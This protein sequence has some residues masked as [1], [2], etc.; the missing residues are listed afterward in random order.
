MTRPELNAPAVAALRESL[1]SADYTHDGIRAAIGAPAMDALA[2]GDFEAAELTTRD[3][4]AIHTLVRLFLIGETVSMNEARDALPF[5][6]AWQLGLVE[7]VDGD[8]RASLDLRPYAADSDIWWVVSD[9][10]T[11]QR[12]ASGRGPILSDHVLGVGGASTTLAQ[13]A[14]RKAVGSA[15]DLGTGCGVQSL[16]LSKHASSVIA[17]DINSRALRLAALTAAINEMEISFREGDLLRPVQ[18]E[19]FDQIVSNPPFV[20]GAGDGGFTYRDSG[21]SGDTITQQLVRTLPALLN[22]GGSAQLLANWMHVEGEDWRERV[23]SWVH[24][25]GCDA[26]IIQRDIQDPA[27]Y[28]S[29]WMSDA[30]DGRSTDHRAR[31]DSWFEWLRE[32]KVEGIGFGFVLL[33]R[34]ESTPVIVTDE[35]TQ[36]ISPPLGAQ[37]TSWFARQ[38]WLRARSDDAVLDSQLTLSADVTLEQ[39]ATRDPDGGWDV[40]GQVLRQESG[41]RWREDVDQVVADLAAGCDGRQSIRELMDV[42]D[43]LYSLAD[44][45]DTSALMSATATAVRHLVARGFLDF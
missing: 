16:H 11:E 6:A 24:G 7:P 44:P 17:T 30:G 35:L 42:L 14:P 1:Q 13:L 40:V 23:S 8:V 19:R 25:N 43:A 15:L 12:R 28:V 27:E 45:L 20:V 9:L 22:P 34:T 2:R 18:D 29:L 5:A 31:Y 4:D 32:H 21:L 10:G 38:D 36:P 37:V 26:W 39:V 33:R 41:F 3:G